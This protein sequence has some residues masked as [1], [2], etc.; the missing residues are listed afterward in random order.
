MKFLRA[1]PQWCPYAPIDLKKAVVYVR[2]GWDETGVTNSA[3]EPA[4]ETTVALAACDAL[5]P[6]GCGVKFANDDTETEYFV[7]SRSTSGGSA[8][9]FTLTLNGDTGTFKLTFDEEETEALAVDADLSAVEAALHSLDTLDNN[10]V[11][12]TGVPGTNYIVTWQSNKEVTAARFT[13]STA[14]T[15]GSATWARTASGSADDSTD[16]IT[17]T[18]G[19]AETVETDGAVTFHG[20]RLEIKIGEGNLTYNEVKNREYLLNRGLLD[21][22]RDGDDTPVD[23]SFDFTWE[24]LTAVTDAGVPTIE[25][26]LKQRGEASGWVTTSADACEPYCVNIEVYYDPGCG[27]ANTELIELKYF[28]HESLDHNL[29]D[30]QVACSGKCNITEATVT[31]G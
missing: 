17:L 5:V 26:A 7:A 3:E 18:A 20:T 14:P 15:G 16:T 8:A 30:S 27:G 28:R 31:R 2:D 23:V 22:V 11:V 29:G 21:T 13:L 6:I 19:L 1:K 10:S 12:V 4:D 24:F 25:D 9:V